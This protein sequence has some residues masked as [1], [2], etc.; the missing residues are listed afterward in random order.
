ML[1]R[2]PY[3]RQGY[4]AAL[5]ILDIVGTGVLGASAIALFVLTAFLRPVWL[6]TFVPYNEFAVI[7]DQL[8]VQYR[9][10]VGP[11]VYVGHALAVICLIG[12][13]QHLISL[14]TG[15]H[16]WD[17][18]RK[19][20]NWMVWPEFA[21]TTALSIMVLGWILGTNTFFEFIT[22]GVCILIACIICFMVE[23]D[24][25]FNGPRTVGTIQMIV[26]V[27]GPTV[28]AMVLS[29]AP[30]VPFFVQ[31]AFSVHRSLSD[32]P[33]WVIASTFGTCVFFQLIG[34]TFI[35][36]R[37]VL[38]DSKWPCAKEPAVFR[39]AYGILGIVW[40]LALS[41]IIAGGILHQNVL[42]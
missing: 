27:W 36:Q 17:G 5:T 2:D 31:F 22:Y 11:H 25:Y 23:A 28:T 38:S 10:A 13:I 12:A 37:I 6:P 35:L 42:Q 34:I 24:G 20:F 29:L 21:V 39:I 40:K 15:M 14:L 41:W 7:D 4:I 19:G 3:I 18:V 8:A 30:W 1:N 33:W 26:N 9:L 32:V 16:Q